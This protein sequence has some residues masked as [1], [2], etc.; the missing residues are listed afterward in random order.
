MARMILPTPPLQ[1]PTSVEMKIASSRPPAT[2]G[3]SKLD[4]RTRRPGTRF[5]RNTTPQRCPIVVSFRRCPQ[6]SFMFPFDPRGIWQIAP[7]RLTS[8]LALPCL[9]GLMDVGQ[10]QPDNVS[11]MI[12]QLK[13]P[14]VGVRRQAADALGEAKDPR[15]VEPLA[16]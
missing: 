10:G 1:M 8:A 7:R 4:P 13:D 6:R 16:T 12:N 3:L 5:F 14:D 15:A 9:L 2:T 11:K